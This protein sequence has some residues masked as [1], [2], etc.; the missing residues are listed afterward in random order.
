MDCN[1]WK[2]FL[3]TVYTNAEDLE[4]YMRA[5]VE[6]ARDEYAQAWLRQLRGETG[7]F[8]FCITQECRQNV[9]I[10]GDM[11]LCGCY[12]FAACFYY[13]GVAVTIWRIV[14]CFISLIYI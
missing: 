14:D 4:S 6:V 5:N 8:L 12:I 7:T 1:V 10:V 2:V 3:E 13:Y 11:Q 9:L